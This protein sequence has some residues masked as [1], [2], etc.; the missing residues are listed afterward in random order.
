MSRSLLLVLVACTPLPSVVQTPDIDPQPSP[1]DGVL[2]VTPN[3]RQVNPHDLVRLTVIGGSGEVTY[4]LEGDAGDLNTETGVWVAGVE[5]GGTD[6]IVVTDTVCEERVSVTI[7]VVPRMDVQPRD[8]MV[9]PGG[10]MT[11]SVEGG[12]GSTSCSLFVDGSGATLSDSCVYLAGD[13]QAQ[14]TVRFVDEETDEIL[15]VWVEVDAEGELLIEGRGGLILPTHASH[16]VN[17]HGGSGHLDVTV[18]SGPLEAEGVLV[19]GLASGRGLVE[20]R[21][22][23]TGERAEVPVDVVAP[24]VPSAVRDGE[25]SSQGIVRSLGDVN[26]DGYEDVA[27]GFIEPSVD[28]HYGGVVAVYAGTALAM[29]PQ[30]VFVVSGAGVGDTAGRGLTSGDVNG[31]GQID[32]IIGIDKADRGAS[33]NGSVR[34]HLGVEGGFFEE[35]PSQI[36]Y[37]MQSYERLGSSL[38]LC[39]FDGDGMLDLA[40]GAMEATDRAVGVPAEDQGGVYVYRGTPAGF[41][42]RADFILYGAYALGGWEPARDLELGAS[43]AAGDLDGDGLCDLVAGAP[44]GLSEDGLVLVYRGTLNDGLLLTREPVTSLEGRHNSELGRRLAVGDLDGDG[45][46]ELGVTA[47]KEDSDGTDVGAIYVFSD[48]DLSGDTPLHLLE[49][50]VWQTKGSRAYD[51]LGSDLQFGQADRQAGLDIIA[52]AY[53]AEDG[54]YGQGRILS[55]SSPTLD[56]STVGA[57]TRS[58]GGAESYDRFG[59]AFDLVGDTDGDGLSELVVLSGFSTAHGIETGGLNHVTAGTGQQ[60]ALLLPGTAAGHNYGAA[61]ARADVDGDGTIDF[62]VGGSGAG[63][64]AVGANAGVVHAWTA[65]SN[66][67]TPFAGGHPTHTGS[68]RFGDVLTTGDVDG[69]GWTD[70]IAV[71]RSDYRPSSLGTEVHNP[72]ECLGSRA[73]AGLLLVYPGGPNGIADEPAL[74]WWGPQSSG[75]I[76]RAVSGFD[77]DGDGRQDIAVASNDWGDGGGF[78]ILPGREFVPGGI[79]VMC[80]DDVVLGLEEHDRLGDGIAPI[81]DVDGDGCDEVAVG[82]TGETLGRDWT[83]QGALRVF[84]GW[85]GA[86]CPTRAEHTTL[87]VKIIGTELGRSVAGGTDIDGDGI[88]DLVVGGAQYRVQ[89]AEHGVAWVVPGSYLLGRSREPLVGGALPEDPDWELLLPEQGLQDRYGVVGPAAGG[90]FGTAVAFVDDP[91]GTL[92]AVGMPQGSTAAQPLTGGVLLYRFDPD[93]GFDPVPWQIVSGEATPG[94]MGSVLVGGEE[95]LIGAPTSDVAGLDLGAAY[96]LRR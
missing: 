82:A 92:V 60:S 3:V 91:S 2:V 74:M 38:A 48:L 88:V 24:Y 31:D 96:R 80:D 71:A 42:E 66:V 19:T 18:L 86:G 9:V 84:W 78:A 26:G 49:E 10:A 14:D 17:A 63:D 65:G 55:W 23:F 4:R 12:S 52:G 22:R 61:L 81:G 56:G 35:E 75:Y 20:V 87:A 11:F 39:D 68:D 30:P 59:Q 40:A 34:I 64:A 69:D 16:R 28:A 27:V 54:P 41:A 1:C 62:L 85:G 25:R 51:Q 57:E 79:T 43:L 33:N 89:F 29:S 83:N 94:G 15:D 77:H 37:G 13:V 58:W 8:A 90:L 73:T 76:R 93:E 53:R 21:D 44:E 72:D 67:P 32:L 5:A 50:A 47:W 46:A 45:D 70:L 6:T 36:L 95:L 7:N